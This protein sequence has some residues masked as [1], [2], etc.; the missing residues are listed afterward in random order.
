MGTWIGGS[1]SRLDTWIVG[2][3]C[4]L[5]IGHSSSAGFQQSAP[6]NLDSKF[7]IFDIS[8]SQSLQ[9]S[10]YSSLLP[11]DLQKLQFCVHSTSNILK[12][13]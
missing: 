10:A 12:I 1:G 4:S 5:E 6:A 9:V 3:R 11:G 8:M 7:S 13:I 2:V